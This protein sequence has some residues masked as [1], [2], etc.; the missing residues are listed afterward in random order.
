M[1]VQPKLTINT[2]GDIYEQE[3][4]AMADKVMRMPLVSSKA[5][6]TQGML[7]SSIQ[8]KCAHCEEEEKKKMPIMRK[9]ESGGGFETS[10]QF[11]SQ[12]SNT[13]GGGHAMPTDTQSFMENRFGRDFSHVRL[14]TDGTAA[15]MSA[16][17]QAKAFTHG[18]DIYFNRGEFQPNTEGG[19]RLLAHELTHIM[20]QAQGEN[21]IIQRTNS[22]CANYINDTTENL[23]PKTGTDAKQSW[24]KLI[25]E[26]TIVNESQDA[27]KQQR[28][29]KSIDIFLKTSSGQ[30]LITE[31]DKLFSSKKFCKETHINLIFVDKVV[32]TVGNGEGINGQADSNDS[33]LLICDNT[34]NYR[35]QVKYQEPDSPG[36]IIPYRQTSEGIFHSYS[37]AESEMAHTLYHELLHIWF[38]NNLGGKKGIKFETGHGDINADVDGNKIEPVFCK[39][40]QSFVKDIDV[41]E[42]EIHKEAQQKDIQQNAPHIDIDKLTEPQVEASKSSVSRGGLATAQA[43][44]IIKGHLGKQFI[45]IAGIDFLIGKA[46]S[47]H[48]GPRLIFMNPNILLGGGA[49]GI[50]KMQDDKDIMQRTLVNPLYFD[51]EL[52]VIAE[53]SPQTAKKYTD[54]V[55]TYVSAGFGKHFGQ[56][57]LEVKGIVIIPDVTKPSVDGGVVLGGGVNF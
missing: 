42:S 51:L 24:E 36:T 48:L 53:I 55:S 16:G 52:G 49:V 3:A 12:L 57:F 39:K 8:R 22:P 54:S 5:Q 1:I 30:W 17:I 43:G 31:L 32:D 19:R 38:I 44:M 47:L 15:T 13:R 18:S 29:A 25:G 4:D 45:G 34:I 21:Q 7:A 26:K 37:D 56:K 14:H 35:I 41:L 40:I 10:P 33:D 46:T 27:E 20:Q 50:R 23:Q 28:A 6:G 2:H 11:S 9:A